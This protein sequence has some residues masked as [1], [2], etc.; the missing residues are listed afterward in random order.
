MKTRPGPAAVV[1]RPILD[2]YMDSAVAVVGCNSQ[3]I[4]RYS[5]ELDVLVVT[6]ERRPST[7]LRIGDVFIDLRFT[8]EKDVLRPTN[9]EH[10]M[11]MAMAKPVRDASLV[12]STSSA[13]NFAMIAESARKASGIRLASALKIVGRAES[14]LA[15]GTLV[16]ADFWLLAASYEFA[17][18]LLLSKEV[19]PSPSHL[20]A[21]LRE[22]SKG[23]PRGF[24][25]MSIGAGLES[26]G[27]A[28]CGARLEGVT[29]LHDVLREGSTE[30]TMDSEWP[31]ARTE[32]VLAKADE[33]MTRAELAECYSFLGQELVDGMTTLLRT[34]PKRTLMSLTE[35]KD[36]LLGERLVRQLGLARSEMAVKLGLDVL[37]QQVSLL[38][39]KS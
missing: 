34:N 10:G 19:I 9:P 7:S 5:C 11:S 15:K 17:Y 1:L 27:R 8:S 31:K 6:G 26:A 24:E 30:A 36:R 33:L 20:L 21:Q 29:V 39:R 3:G 28:G 35:G 16:D 37:R 13:A 23:N 12:L 14:A 32:I 4:G 38:S 2:M 18:A 25:G 22:G